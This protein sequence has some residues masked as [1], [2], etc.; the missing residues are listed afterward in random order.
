MT[1]QTAPTVDSNIGKMCPTFNCTP[2]SVQAQSA[3]PQ[4][5]SV[6]K[7]RDH[8]IFVANSVDRR[9]P[10]W[11]ITLTLDKPVRG[12]FVRGTVLAIAY[13][14]VTFLIQANALKRSLTGIA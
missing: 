3:K 14:E 12:S 1:S 5:L 6:F 4:Q 7:W 13:P 9:R 10:Q 8:K 11:I 2:E